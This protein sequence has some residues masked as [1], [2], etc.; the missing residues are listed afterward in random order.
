MSMSY[1]RA[2]FCN[3][4]FAIFTRYPQLI[5][6]GVKKRFDEICVLVAALFIDLPFHF[7]W[8]ASSRAELE[9][10]ETAIE[11]DCH[12]RMSRLRTVV[13]RTGE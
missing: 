2:L 13:P 4:I 3:P 1:K 10:R 8:A 5:Y 12:A 6:V 7:S 9:W 11:G